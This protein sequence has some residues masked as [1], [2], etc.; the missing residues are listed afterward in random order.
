M[1]AVY[2]VSDTHGYV[3]EL[4]A[5]LEGEGLVADDHWTGLDAR[6]W[7]LGDFFDRGPDGI[8]VLELV[9]RLEQESAGAVR[10]VIGNHEIL[11]IGKRMFGSMQSLATSRT[12]DDLWHL[13]EGQASDQARLTDEHVEWLRGLPMLALDQ[14]QLLAHADS[15]GYLEW[16]DTIEDINEAG[17]ASMQSSEIVDW[18]TL[19]RRL[20]ERY[21]YLGPEGITAA[22]TMLDTLG[23]ERIVHGHSIA[24]DLARVPYADIT[25]AFS[26]ADG[27]A[28]GIDGGIYMGGPCL[29]TRLA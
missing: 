5:A 25:E 22:R 13:C 6:L 17:R 16:G 24:A 2:A 8:A 10:A 18:W 23:G 28:L 21:A 1:T 9:R 20:T 26:Y 7:F 14:G 29:L 15:L 4:R 11:A 12:F 27:L 19:W 3:D